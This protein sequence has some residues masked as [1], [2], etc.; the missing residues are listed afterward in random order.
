M[1]SILRFIKESRNKKEEEQHKEGISILDKILNDKEETS[2]DDFVKDFIRPNG[3]TIYAFITDK[4]KDAIKV[5]YTDQH[6]EKRI[7]Q[8]K[9]IYGKEAGEVECLGYWSSE[10]FTRKMDISNLFTFIC[11]C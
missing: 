8:W 3:P 10:E 5:G 1:M 4:V 7:A 9:E 6:P 11:K 2:V